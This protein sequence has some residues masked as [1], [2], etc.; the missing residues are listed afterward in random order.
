[1]KKEITIYYKDSN[2]DEYVTR[3]VLTQEGNYYKLTSYWKIGKKIETY[4]SGL[5]LTK[6][7]ANKYILQ[8]RKE[9]RFDHF[10]YQFVMWGVL[11]NLNR[12]DYELILLGLSYLQL[13]LQKQYEEE[14]DKTKK[15]KIYNE[16]LEIIRLS[17]IISKQFIE[18]Y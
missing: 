15:D 4:V 3:S 16:H 18:R 10:E 2:Q 17:N 13:H 5:K 7:E 11:M 9:N 1:M 14:K 8:C 6:S 12:H